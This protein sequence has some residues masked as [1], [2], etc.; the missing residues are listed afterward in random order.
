MHA[1]TLYGNVDGNSGNYSEARVQLDK[2]HKIHPL[3]PIVNTKLKISSYLGLAKFEEALGSAR[4]L[5]ERYPQSRN[6]TL[7]HVIAV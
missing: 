4:A 3:Y 2:V 7:Y 5:L 6:G 1:L